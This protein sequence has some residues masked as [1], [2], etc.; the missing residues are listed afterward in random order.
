MDKLDIRIESI[1][2]KN[3]KNVVNGTVELNNILKDSH[4]ASITGI[5]GQN[6]SGKTALIWSFEILKDA[7]SG[8]SLPE[9][10]FFYIHQNNHTA[11][12]C[13]DLS[14]LLNSR[15]YSVSYS[16]GLSKALEKKSY[17]SY[18]CLEL[19]AKEFQN[20]PT[21][22][23][24]KILEVKNTA[25]EELNI[26]GYGPEV[27]IAE[28]SSID[29]QA[30]QKLIVLQALAKEKNS[31][32]IFNDKMREFL[33][34]SFNNTYYQ[35]IEQLCFYARMNL[36][37][38]N[39]NSDTLFNMNLLPLSVRLSTQN[40]IT[41]ADILPVGLSQNTTN[42]TSFIIVKK[43]IHQIDILL[44]NIIPGLHVDIVEI[45][46]Q[47]DKNGEKQIVFEL[48]SKRNELTTPLKYESEGI[49]KILCILSSLIAMYNN[50]SIFV[51]IDELDAGIFE[52][53]LGEF[54]DVINK[55][56]KGQLLFTSHNMRPLEVLD[57]AN[58]CFTTTNPTNKYIKF[59]GVKTNN[60]LRTLLLRTID[61]GGQK[62]PVYESTSSYQIGKAFRKAGALINE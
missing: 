45:A 28:M 26:C 49:K 5:Y 12:I 24:T 27:R 35:I 30:K 50:K 59:T 40:Y 54:L 4:G 39:K 9:D 19:S 7:L 57:P 61:L 29:K 23:K 33:K 53:L 31:S 15:P 38:L 48:V 18:E 41:K 16:L 60:N 55:T 21:I 3:V 37:V 17:I 8:V 62:E 42:E 34:G 22:R 10:A 36:F 58:I 43:I 2:I 47:L 44:Q 6:G 13:V 11:N 20:S 14:I 32:Y 52:Y 56:G 51:A 25:N 1:T 46:Q